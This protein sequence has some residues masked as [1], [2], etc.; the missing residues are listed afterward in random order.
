MNCLAEN[1]NCVILFRKQ[2]VGRIIKEAINEKIVD[3]SRMLS[4]RMRNV[5]WKS[6]RS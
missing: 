2:P 6:A 5:F 1:N 3:S 4:H